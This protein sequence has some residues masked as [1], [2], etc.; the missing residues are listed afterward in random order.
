MLWIKN[1]RLV[2]PKS[3]TDKIC[4]I[5]IERDRIAGII[6]PGSAEQKHREADEIIDAAGMVV[7]PGLIDVHV[8]FREPGFT[9]KEDVATGA[10]AAAA[11]AIRRSSAWPTQN[12]WWTMR[13]PSLIFG[14]ERPECRFR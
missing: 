14:S 7:A 11:E 13:K 10:A 5:C 1:G 8:H 6:P 3:Q 9:Y 12:R 2:D 4:D